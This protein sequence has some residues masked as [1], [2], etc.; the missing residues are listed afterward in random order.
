MEGSGGLNF[1]QRVDEA[2]DV[3]VNLTVWM[4]PGDGGKLLPN[5][6]RSVG[7]EEQTD[8]GHAD[9]GSLGNVSG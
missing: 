8:G 5:G 9:L 3:S 1:A 4:E 7:R 6:E 2:V